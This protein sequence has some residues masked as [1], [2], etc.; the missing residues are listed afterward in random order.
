MHPAPASRKECRQEAPWPPQK[1]FPSC[2]NRIGEDTYYR[3]NF[4]V[5]LFMANLYAG[6]KQEF[7]E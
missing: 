4:H 5:K 1:S 6:L 2:K 3:P 7:L